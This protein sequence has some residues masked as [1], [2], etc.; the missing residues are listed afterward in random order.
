VRIY[1]P[2]HPQSAE[3]LARP[4]LGRQNVAFATSCRKALAHRDNCGLC[5]FAAIAKPNR[6]LVGAS[7]G[8]L[9]M[10]HSQPTI[11]GACPVLGWQNI[12]LAA[13]FPV[14]A[15]KINPLDRY[16][17]VAAYAVKQDNLS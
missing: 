5:C 12:A 16:A 1:R 11:L 6:P 14:A 4:L 3:L 9:R 8:R 10:Q 2:L 13:R 17:C 7:A 15:G